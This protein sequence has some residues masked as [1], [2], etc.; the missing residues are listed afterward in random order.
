[1]RTQAPQHAEPAGH[2]IDPA[3]KTASTNK[4]VGAAGV[5]PPKPPLAVP[6][7]AEPAADAW[8]ASADLS[9]DAA[10]SDGDGWGAEEGEWGAEVN[11]GGQGGKATA[12]I[13]AL[14]DEREKRSSEIQGGRTA[15]DAGGF[16]PSMAET[17]RGGG[18]DG[19]GS[20]V[21]SAGPGPGAGSPNVPAVG[22]AGAERR[23]PCF[24]AK[25]VSFMPEPWGAQ[26]SGV[27][28]KDMQNRLRRYREQEEDR[29][30]V[31]ALDQALGLND[32]G[33]AGSN[34][35]GAGGAGAAG[36]GEK[37]ERTPAR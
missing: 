29:G 27:E 17:R 18:G 22:G 33:G 16:T 28:D 31:A 19:Q 25:A 20:A 35:R 24:P 13:E 32:D 3:P 37:Y 26:V 23:R 36:I 9:W 21:E 12:D 1:M 30:L 10:P 11:P 8:G 7:A 6:P 4:A 34:R 2:S 5:S 14:L 15:A